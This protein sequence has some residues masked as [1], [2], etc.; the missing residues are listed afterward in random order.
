MLEAGLLAKT[1]WDYTGLTLGGDIGAVWVQK[2]KT[3]QLTRQGCQ[4]CINPAE[5][6]YFWLVSIV[7][8]VVVFFKLFL[9]F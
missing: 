9:K 7:V 1:A 5:L 8:V 6:E 2:T 4:V 3:H